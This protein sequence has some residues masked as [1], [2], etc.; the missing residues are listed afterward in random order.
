[1][2]QALAHLS[3]HA[4]CSWDLE[5]LLPICLRFI[6]HDKKQLRGE[7]FYSD[8]EFGLQPSILWKSQGRTVGG[9]ASVPAVKTQLMHTVYG[10]LHMPCPREWHC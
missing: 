10:G 3:N 4:F 9:G 5:D 7:R 1:M 8:S 6:F 2:L